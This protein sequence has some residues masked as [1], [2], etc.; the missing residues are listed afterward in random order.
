MAFYDASRK[1]L[2]FEKYLRRNSVEP[3]EIKNSFLKLRIS[4]EEEIKIFFA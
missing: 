3:E 4:F 2:Q 1:L